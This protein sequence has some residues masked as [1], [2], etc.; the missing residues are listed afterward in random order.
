MLLPYAGTVAYGLIS[1]LLLSPLLA[2]AVL[3]LPLEPFA[4]RLGLAVF[5]CMPTALSSG[6][7]MT[8][9]RLG[10]HSCT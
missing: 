7:A 5:V 1:I 2:P 9:V 6:I 4:L 10:R 8:Q 3:A